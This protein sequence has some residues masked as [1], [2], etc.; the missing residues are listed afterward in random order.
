MSS[1]APQKSLHVY[2]QRHNVFIRSLPIFFTV[3]C[4]QM[5]CTAQMSQLYYMQKCMRNKARRNE[6]FYLKVYS[7]LC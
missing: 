3:N 7:N 1:N 5:K 4:V 2:I 6:V